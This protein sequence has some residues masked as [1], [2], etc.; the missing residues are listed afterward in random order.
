MP[1]ER[2][3]DTNILLYGYD[4]D[5]P[6]K[7]TVAQALLERAWL[8]PGSTAI[9]VQVLQEFYVNFVRCG[10]KA[11]EAATLINDFCKWPVTDNSLALFRLGLSVQKQWQLSL[12]DA[13]I[14]AA[15]QMSGAQELYTEDLNHG[16][17]YG[18]VRVINPFVS[19]IR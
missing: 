17:C 6:A 10:H 3:L 9:S 14:V 7:R 19:T 15:A 8:E 4:L 2:F 18:D 13:M 5:S 1:A 16:Q 11:A 12:W